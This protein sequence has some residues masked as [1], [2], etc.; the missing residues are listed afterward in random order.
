[1][2]DPW[3]LRSNF[4]AV[5]GTVSEEA[6]LSD[7]KALSALGLG[8]APVSVQRVRLFLRPDS[9]GSPDLS[10]AIFEEIQEQGGPFP[11]GTVAWIDIASPDV[12]RSPWL[13]EPPRV[14]YGIGRLP[15]RWAVLGP[16]ATLLMEFGRE[17]GP[18]EWIFLGRE[19]QPISW[20]IQE[21]II[22]LT[23]KEMGRPLLTRN[24]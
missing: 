24:R 7:P 3:S 13:L 20:E 16:L 12:F 18:G 14:A 5:I 22:L 10:R 15:V 17:L 2:K 1:V 21:R 19:F 11:D 6:H 23:C 4:R 9:A 8:D